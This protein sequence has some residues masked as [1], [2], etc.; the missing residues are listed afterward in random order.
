[1][2][3]LHI[4]STLIKESTSFIPVLLISVLLPATHTTMAILSSLTVLCLL[5]AAEVI[6]GAP[7]ALQ[8]TV[9]SPSL[10]RTVVLTLDNRV[11]GPRFEALATLTTS[12]PALS[13]HDVT[14][15][16]APGNSEVIGTPHIHE[17]SPSRHVAV[18]R[19]DAIYP[20]TLAA[21]HIPRAPQSHA[22]DPDALVCR[23]RPMPKKHCSGERVYNL[24]V[25]NAEGVLPNSARVFGTLVAVHAGDNPFFSPG[26]H[27]SSALTH[28]A[29]TGLPTQVQHLGGVQRAEN[30][31]DSKV[32][33]LFSNPD[34]PEDS[35]E[36]ITTIH[37][38]KALRR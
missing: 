35:Q 15:V 23:I 37:R 33:I 34:Y 16:W 14:L 7:V 8:P 13:L 6:S 26:G 20:V 25:H 1:M 17:S 29:R 38:R 31:E 12:S 36:T 24:A 27:A 21:V 28:L 9:D 19:K 4:R 3:D 32:N 2:L 10:C 30:D 18:V 5:F 11:V 22:N